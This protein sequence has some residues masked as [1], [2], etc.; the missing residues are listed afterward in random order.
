[1]RASFLI[2]SLAASCHALA[3]ASH[4]TAD[5]IFT[6]SPNALTAI[7]NSTYKHFDCG[8]SARTHASEH[9]NATI[10]ALHRHH[11][12]APRTPT[13]LAQRAVV[14]IKVPTYFHI[15]TKASNAGSIT[16]AMASAQLAAMNARYNP[17][18]ISF[19]LLGT[20][21]TVNDVWAVGA[22][23]QDDAAMKAAL[24]KGTYGALNIYFQTDLAGGVLGTCTLPS[25]IGP[26]NPPQSV[27]VSDGCNVQANTMPGGNVYAFNTGM[28]A[29]HETGHWLG[30]LHTFEGYSCSGDGDFIADTRA[31]SV[32][33]D[34]CPTSPAKNSCPGI[35]VAGTDPIH[36][37][38]DYSDD[39]C[40]QGF[41]PLQVKRMQ[42][43]W[44]Q[45][46][47][48]R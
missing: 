25:N 39:A 29:V 21:T 28:T 20:T 40:Y 26:G 48:G 17:Y 41:T 32:S 15:V 9:F 4:I 5:S 35:S 45:Y 47:L 13:Q 34:G 18:G 7:A 36:N 38:M 3:S 24:R 11:A 14:A 1:M 6:A 27:Y 30:L 19:K 44:G 46:R 42:N 43:L 2:A 31:E 12:D 37:Y 10:A 16:P 8:V 33:T 23:P 22:T